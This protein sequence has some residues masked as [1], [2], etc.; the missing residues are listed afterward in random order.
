MVELGRH[1]CLCT[2][3]TG[4]YSRAVNQLSHQLTYAAM[5]DRYGY[6]SFPLQTF[7]GSL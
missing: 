1:R 7:G 5:N 4:H 6:L 2:N 3:G